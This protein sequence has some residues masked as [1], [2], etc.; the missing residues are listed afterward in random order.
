M[1]TQDFIDKARTT[2]LGQK[3]SLQRLLASSGLP[4]IS[5]QDDSAYSNL[6]QVG[7]VAIS[8]VYISCFKCHNHLYSVEEVWFRQFFD[9]R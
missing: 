1:F 5:E 2:L 6:N 4:L 8:M 9:E 7:T 3:I